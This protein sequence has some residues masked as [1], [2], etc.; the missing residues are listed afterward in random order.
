[1]AAISHKL[2]KALKNFWHSK[3][4][5]HIQIS[6][7]CCIIYNYNHANRPTCLLWKFFFT[8]ANTNFRIRVLQFNLWQKNLWEP[9]ASFFFVFICKQI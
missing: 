2:A 1:M 7:L 9:V 6:N 4:F 8:S 5:A 3:K